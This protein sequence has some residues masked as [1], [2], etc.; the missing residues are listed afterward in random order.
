MKQT[1]STLEQENK[2]LACAKADAET[3]VRECFIMSMDLYG[4]KPF[5]FPLEVGE[6]ERVLAS[7]KTTESLEKSR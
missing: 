2:D 6:L 1:K 5:L 7:K 3:K 4:Y